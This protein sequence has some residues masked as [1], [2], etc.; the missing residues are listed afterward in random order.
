LLIAASAVLAG[1][2]V[3][4]A[5][6]LGFVGLIVPH[7][8]RLL[9]GGDH[10]YRFLRARSWAPP[11]SPRATCFRACCF[12]PYEFPVGITMSLMGGPFFVYLLLKQRRKIN[13]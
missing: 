7:A 8:V 2:A 9:I 3:S 1:A 13:A 6:L 5:G 12:A 11:S 4:F 10:R